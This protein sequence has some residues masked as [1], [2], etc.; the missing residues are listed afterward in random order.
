MKKAAYIELAKTVMGERWR[1][2][3]L[4]SRWRGDACRERENDVWQNVWLGDEG[5]GDG[6]VL[7]ESKHG[8]AHEG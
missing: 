7:W 3:R 2:G 6:K 4:V 5:V 8:I 1:D